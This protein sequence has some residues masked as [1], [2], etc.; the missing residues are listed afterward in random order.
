VSTTV[1]PA[2]TLVGRVAP[3]A[4]KASWLMVKMVYNFF[5]TVNVAL[6]S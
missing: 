1:T 2:R 5:G 4:G 6:E 3:K